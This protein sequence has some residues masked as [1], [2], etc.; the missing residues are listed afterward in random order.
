M[1]SEENKE[2]GRRE[3]NIKKVVNVALASF[4]KYGIEGAKVSE[5]ARVAS[6][7][8]RS[9]FRYF[10]T[11]SDLVYAAALL[12]WDRVKKT[13]EKSGAKVQDSKK[14]G[15]EDIEDILN[16]YTN[17]YFD[18]YEQLIFVHEAESYLYRSGKDLLVKNNVLSSFE[19]SLDPLALAIKKGL[20]DNSVRDDI[21]LENIY[22][23]TYDSLLGLMQKLAIRKSDD[24]EQVEAIK[25][26]LQDFCHTLTL[27]FKKA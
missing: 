26:R 27:S 20:K 16:R 22:L 15:I 4:V 13:V 17:I 1:V 11:K 24:K 9:V 21:N 12:F 10:E 3:T 6:L 23:N 14:R 25:Q 19:T 5:I 7:T 2:L 18:S 8:E